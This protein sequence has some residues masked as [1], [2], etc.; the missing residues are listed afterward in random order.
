MLEPGQAADTI[1]HASC[2]ALNGRGV[3]ITGPSGSGKSLLALQLMAFGAQLVADDRVIL[4]RNGSE[5]KAQAPQNLTGLIE[6]RGIGI[7]HAS[8]LEQAPILVVVDLSQVETD[9][10]PRKRE[11]VLLGVKLPLL[12]KSETTDFPAALTQ[13]LRGGRKDPG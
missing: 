7:L 6:A 4:I 2:V 9:R 5:L 11:T 3:L 12:H 13:Y 10:L 1:V 8:A